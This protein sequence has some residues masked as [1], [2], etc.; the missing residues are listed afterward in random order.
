MESHL[1]KTQQFRSLASLLDNLSSLLH[2]WIGIVSGNH[3]G[4]IQGQQDEF[5]KLLEQLKTFEA[6]T[7]QKKQEE[8]QN[9][10]QFM[11][12]LAALTSLELP[13]YTSES[14]QAAIRDLESITGAANTSSNDLSSL[15]LPENFD[16]YF[17]PPTKK[18]RMVGGIGRRAGGRVKKSNYSA[19]DINMFA[20]PENDES[21][22]TFSTPP[23]DEF[24]LSSLEKLSEQLRL[25]S[26][27]IESPKTPSRSSHHAPFDYDTFFQQ[28]NA[29]SQAGSNE[30]DISPRGSKLLRAYGMRDDMNKRG[31]QKTKKKS[32]LSAHGRGVY[33][34]EDANYIGYPFYENEDR[35]LFCVFDGHVDKNAAIAATKI[36]PEV[37]KKPAT[38][39]C[40]FNFIFFLILGIK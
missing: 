34:M 4:D 17:V 29:A 9:N 32:K 40:F 18:K 22:P 23:V 39:F 19:V 25:D 33:Q 26:T 1:L 12:A 8:T 27:K 10:D 5:K 35:A 24:G 31:M 14:T 13:E 36:F 2:D 6:P 38:L 11:D 21:Q 28:M 3:Q 7:L 15:T 20:P 30:A 37:K 16:N